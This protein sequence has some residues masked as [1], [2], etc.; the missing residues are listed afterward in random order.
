MFT[1]NHFNF[2]VLDLQRSLDFYAEALELRPVRERRT[3]SYQLTYLGD[4]KSDFTLE[5]T[6]LCRRTTDASIS[7]KIRTDTGLKY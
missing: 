5:L 6:W 4:G 7:S 1:F 3:D 2:N